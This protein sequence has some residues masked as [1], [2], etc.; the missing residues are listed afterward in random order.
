MHVR[1]VELDWDGLV[2]PRS[3]RALR[4]GR[5]GGQ[6]R[7]IA[8]RRRPI[9]PSPRRAGAQGGRVNPNNNS[10]TGGGRSGRILPRTPR[11]AASLSRASPCC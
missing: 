7:S 2:L 6:G 3:E 5:R 4:T 10:G 9:G 11:R 1:A 8:A